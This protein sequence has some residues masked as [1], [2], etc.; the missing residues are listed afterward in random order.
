MTSLEIER[1]EF[2]SFV[3]ISENP[4]NCFYHLNK[5]EIVNDQAIIEM[6]ASLFTDILAETDMIKNCK[7]GR[8][9]SKFKPPI[10]L[11]DYL[12]RLGK[13]FLCS[14]ECFVMAIIYIDRI[15]E[16]SSHFIVNSLNIH[17]FNYFS[18]HLS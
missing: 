9:T 10:S 12:T 6:I 13:C 11:K 16:N 14:Q 7:A 1:Y 8:F 17:R 5:I 18:F 15:T 2:P 4:Y 3:E